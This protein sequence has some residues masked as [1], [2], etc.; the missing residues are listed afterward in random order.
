MDELGAAGAACPRAPSPGRM[1][2]SSGGTGSITSAMGPCC[3]SGGWR[4]VSASPAPHCLQHGWRRDASLVGG[5]LG[6]CSGCCL[7]GRTMWAGL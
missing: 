4:R 7:G 5:M 6:V 2:E 1:D 3:C